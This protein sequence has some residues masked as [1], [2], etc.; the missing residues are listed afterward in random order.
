MDG[1]DDVGESQRTMPRER[2]GRGG[3]ELE[4]LNLGGLKVNDA[5][6]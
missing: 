2:R 3:N 6:S 5:F 4:L 1:R